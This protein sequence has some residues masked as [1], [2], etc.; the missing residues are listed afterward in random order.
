MRAWNARDRAR[1]DG[2]TVTPEEQA[3][4]AGIPFV[5][6]L[7]VQREVIAGAVT[8]DARDSEAAFAAAVAERHAAVGI[9]GSSGASRAKGLVASP[10]R[11]AATVSRVTTVTAG[12][13]SAAEC[14][15]AAAPP[16]TPLD[17]AA[18]RS[19]PLQPA[20]ARP[21][22][23]PQAPMQAT[24]HLRSPLRPALAVAAAAP[25]QPPP[26]ASPDAAGGVQIEAA[27]AA[28]AAPSPASAVTPAGVPVALDSARR[29]WVSQ[30]SPRQ[31]AGE[32]SRRGVTKLLARAPTAAP[33]RVAVGAAAA[34]LD[35]PPEPSS[36]RPSAGKRR[37]GGGSAA[38]RPPLQS[39]AVAASS[40]SVN[41]GEEDA[42]ARL[43]AASLPENRVGGGGALSAPLPGHPFLMHR[44]VATVL[45][46]AAAGSALAAR[47][48]GGGGAP[49]AGQGGRG[50]S[51]APRS[52]A[53]P[54]G[55]GRS[56]DKCSVM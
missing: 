9:G 2:I 31:A 15:P 28:A 54:P 17:G 37:G 39:D 49:A 24:V 25:V 5:S 16:S 50:A 29:Q 1:L 48:D 11:S 26:K 10:L 41:A 22:H 13:P 42:V 34:L 19:Q 35:L 38:Q 53:A 21:N 33:P 52:K 20:A 36:R 3:R 46:A 44:D 43:A 40:C 51:S 47:G 23:A 7:A 55:G 4:Y 12:A 32:G 45:V 56:H 14:A 8:A 30:P 6:M 18:P 27:I